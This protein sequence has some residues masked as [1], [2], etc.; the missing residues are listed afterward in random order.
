VEGVDGLPHGVGVDS[1]M[2]DEWKLPGGK[3][4]LTIKFPW[5]KGI[6]ISIHLMQK[7]GI[8]VER[9]EKRIPVGLYKQSSMWIPFVKNFLRQIFSRA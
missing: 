6:A 5:E 1:T 3:F 8:Q 7:D 9:W 4:D 2:R